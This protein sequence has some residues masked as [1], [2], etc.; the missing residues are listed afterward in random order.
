MWKNVTGLIFDEDAYFYDCNQQI[1][2]N[3]TKKKLMDSDW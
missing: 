3:M 1:Y 2:N